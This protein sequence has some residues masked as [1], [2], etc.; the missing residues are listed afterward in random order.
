M[1]TPSTGMDDGSAT[2]EISGGTPPYQVLWETGDTSRTINNLF[3]DWYEFVV[4][5]AN[6]CLVEGGVMVQTIIGVID[7]E[8]ITSY[9]IGPNPTNGIVYIDLALNEPLNLD[10]QIFNSIGEIVSIKNEGFIFNE[11]FPLDFS[12]LPAGFYYISLKS[13]GRLLLSDRIF[14]Y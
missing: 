3:G 7:R 9:S 4:V 11:K 13:D 1:S 14:K 10:V 12:D 2:V 8:K 6:G 5:D